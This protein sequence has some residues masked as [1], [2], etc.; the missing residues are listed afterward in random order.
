MEIGDETWAVSVQD[1]AA[2]PDLAKTPLTGIQILMPE[3]RDFDPAEVATALSVRQALA[4]I[5]V[6]GAEAERL[7]S[8]ITLDNPGADLAVERMP[9]A[10]SGQATNLPRV[11]ISTDPAEVVTLDLVRMRAEGK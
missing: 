3:M 2:L 11:A 7:K 9:A 6:Q 1:Q 8:L 4:M 10:L 5:G